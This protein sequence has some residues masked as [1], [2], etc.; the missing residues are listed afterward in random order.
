[1]KKILLIILFVSTV[2]TI[3]FIVWT[4]YIWKFSKCNFVG[5]YEC[6]ETWELNISEDELIQVI[7]ELKKENPELVIPNYG[8][9]EEIR[10][11]YWYKIVFYYSD[12]NEKVFT[13]IR[14]TSDRSKTIIALISI[15]PYINNDSILYSIKSNKEINRDYDYFENIKQIDKFENVIVGPIQNKI[16]P[17]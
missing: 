8:L 5:S 6:A 9:P 7:R 4:K 3:S 17:H 14:S 11:E 13:W 2:L 1:M 15:A 16:H 12:T 10:S